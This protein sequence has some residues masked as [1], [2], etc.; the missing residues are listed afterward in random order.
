MCPTQNRKMQ[1][2]RLP[3]WNEDV[4]PWNMPAIKNCWLWVT[5]RI[6][7]C[8]HA[9]AV[10]LAPWIIRFGTEDV[11]KAMQRHFRCAMCGTRGCVFGRPQLDGNGIEPF[12]RKDKLVRLGGA[13][14]SPSGEVHWQTEKRKQAEYLAKYPSGDA[15]GEFRGTG[16]LRFMC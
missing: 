1:P 2:E 13:W 4:V 5:C 10:P 12:P 7:Y 16:T 14:P 6:P 8:G 15:L 3:I 11:D 9:R